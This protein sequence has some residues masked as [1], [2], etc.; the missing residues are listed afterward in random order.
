MKT[1]IKEELL[2]QNYLKKILH[3]NAVTGVFTWKARSVSMFKPGKYQLRSCNIWNTKNANKEAGCIWTPKNRKTSYLIIQITLNGKK[4]LY[5]AHRLAILY[6]EGHFPPE[7]VDHIDG[8][9]RNNRRNNLRE[10]SALENN[11]NM[12]MQTNNTSG[13]T[14]VSWDKATQKWQVQISIN[15]KR[16]Y[17]GLFTDKNDAIA[18]RKQMEIEHGY[19]INHGRN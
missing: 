5:L 9:G 1:I 7:Q 13:C 6:T 12:P 8:N 15:G 11:K 18:K 2:S 16:I 14:G 19:H 17:G 4:K 10:V 3:Y